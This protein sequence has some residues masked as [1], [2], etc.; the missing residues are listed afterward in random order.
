M[1]IQTWTEP[2]QTF[3]HENT[4]CELKLDWIRLGV[5]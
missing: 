2:N 1:D 3:I 4:M 5:G